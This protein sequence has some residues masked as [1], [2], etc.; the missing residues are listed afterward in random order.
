LRKKEYLLTTLIPAKHVEVA[1]ADKKQEY[2]K[3]I[4]DEKSINVLIVTVME[5]EL[6]KVH[7]FRF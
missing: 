2:D 6:Q 5:P 7:G 3:H 4:K 1:E